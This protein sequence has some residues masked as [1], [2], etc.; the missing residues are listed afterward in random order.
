MALSPE[1]ST[2]AL[3]MADLHVHQEPTPHLDR[4][5]AQREGRPPYDWAAWRRRLVA[6]FPPGPERLAQ[7]GTMRPVPLEVD[8]DDE[9]FVARVADVLSEH[10]RSGGSYIEVRCGGD[11]VLRNGFMEL[12]RRAERQVQV[13]FPALRAEPLAIVMPGA[14]P[15]SELAAK[16]DGCVRLA[17]E[18]LAG[19]DLM[20]FPYHSEAD[21][22]VAHRLAGRFA[23]AGLGITAHAGELSTANIAAAA[24]TPG[25]TR[26]GHGIHAIKDPALVDLL[27][28]QDITLECALSCNVL[29]GV[30]QSLAEHPLVRFID[31]GVK[32][33]LATDDPVQVG[34]T[35]GAEYAA[36]ASLGLT[37]NQ[38]LG[39]TRNAIE[40]AFTTEQRRAE[41]LAEID[42]AAVSAAR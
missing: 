4:V 36:A 33:T 29:F 28:D 38:L 21:W 32:V 19:V 40:A 39:L 10:A 25:L 2:A 3:P 17:G 13:D 7:V 35:I 11:V 15:P 12:F 23:D 37:H 30:V 14:E 27:I 26:I 20:C 1:H 9:L 42:A 24:A 8:A 34:T 16:V 6:E 22:T 41:L 31:A 18:G 5:L